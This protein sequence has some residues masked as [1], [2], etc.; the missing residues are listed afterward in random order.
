M[1]SAYRQYWL[2]T[3][4]L[5]SVTI[6]GL[7]M[8][9][10]GWALLKFPDIPTQL[11]FGFILAVFLYAY[12]F[13]HRAA[14]ELSQ[15]ERALDLLSRG[16]PSL[17][18]LSAVEECL[19]EAMQLRQQGR[20]NGQTNFAI[21]YDR[22]EDRFDGSVTEDIG[23]IDTIRVFLFFVGLLFTLIGVVQ[24]FAS[25]QF[26]TNPEEAKMYSFTIIKALGLAYLPAAACMGSTLVLFV[27]S[28]VLQSRASRLIS[29][30]GNMLYRVAVLGKST[31]NAEMGQSTLE[32][33][34]VINAQAS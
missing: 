5:L 18:K 21:L 22:I 28:N 12:G 32:L 16:V 25:Q 4:F 19:A 29:D 14:K 26:P 23:R 15:S 6:Y 20:D 8:G 11:S 2:L 9:V 17:G 24:G 10:V 33:R 31:K 13:G 27:L 7:Y 34:R 3:A 1:S 30:F